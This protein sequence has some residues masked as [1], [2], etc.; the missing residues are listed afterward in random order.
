MTYLLFP[1]IFS[2][3]LPSCHYFRCIFHSIDDAH[4]R[5]APAQVIF[6]TVDDLL[7]GWCLVLIKQSD[8]REDHPRCT[9]AALQGIM[10]RKSL[11]DRMQ[12]TIFCKAFDGND[13]LA[14]HITDSNRA[15]PYRFVIYQNRTGSAETY[16]AA[17][18]CS[19]ESEM[20]P[21][22]PK[23]DSVRVSDQFSFLVVQFEP[24]CLF[25]VCVVLFISLI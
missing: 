25:H 8:S 9:V 14:G 18:F 6:K 2:L 16:P 11:L 4:M 15:R 24:D 21:Q 13:T 12:L 7:P 17:V 19:C 20:V 10:V 5:P 22:N 3:L 1:V 23:Q